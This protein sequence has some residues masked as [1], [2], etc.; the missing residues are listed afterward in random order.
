MGQGSV[1]LQS[2]F[3]D[4]QAARNAQF[5]CGGIHL[6]GVSSAWTDSGAGPD[7]TGPAPESIRSDR[8]REITSGAWSR[9]FDLSRAG[10]RCQR[11]YIATRVRRRAINCTRPPSRRSNA[12]QPRSAPGSEP[13]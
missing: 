2:F 9:W 13:V 3:S 11:A 5:L 7:S 12:A 4:L 8:Y 6:M 10:F 1:R